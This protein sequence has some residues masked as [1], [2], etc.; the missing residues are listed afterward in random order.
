M[1]RFRTKE[2]QEKYNTF[3]AHGSMD[4]GCALCAKEPIRVFTHWNIVVN[5]FPYDGVA[6]KHDM[7]LPKRHI[8]EK[9][10]S[11]Q[12]KQELFDVKGV[13]LDDHYDYI[14]ESTN[15]TKSILEH[16]HLHLIVEA[17]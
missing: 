2:T 13:Y 6:K 3:R 10:L 8:D 9:G 16:F 7:I 15:H 4:S 11:D 5:D 17:D 1:P 14:I 12:E